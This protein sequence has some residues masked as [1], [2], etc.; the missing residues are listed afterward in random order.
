MVS[1]REERSR[2]VG[3]MERAEKRRRMAKKALFRTM[4]Y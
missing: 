2:W 1:A 3:M 4:R